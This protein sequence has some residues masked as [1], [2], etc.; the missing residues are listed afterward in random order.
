MKTKLL[1][2]DNIDKNLKGKY[3]LDQIK[4]EKSTIKHGCDIWNIYD[5]LYLDCM[6]M[7]KLKIELGKRLNC[8]LMIHC[9]L[10]FIMF[11]QEDIYFT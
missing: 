4:R 7:P 3:L 9:L 1:G 2:K 6:K 5:F 11:S 10:N 8:T